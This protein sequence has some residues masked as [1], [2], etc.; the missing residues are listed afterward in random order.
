I[1]PMDTPGLSMSPIVDMTTAHSFNQVF[2]DDMRLPVSLR[3][4]EEG[5][6][7]RLAKVTLANERV[8]LSSAGSLWGEGPSAQALL[9]L[10]RESVEPGVGVDDPVVRDRLA[11]L[12][13]EAEVLRLNR[14]RSLSAT[15]QG[16]T[17]G[18]EASIQK[19]MADEHGQHVMALAKDL[20]GTNGMLAGSGPAGAIPARLRH[21][22]TEIR[23]PRGAASQ[24]PDVDP[25]WH[26]G[27]LFSPALTLGGGT[28]AVQRN[29]VAEQVLGLPR[30]PDV[31]RG[32]SWAE[33]RARKALAT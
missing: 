27:Y 5:D 13:C 14:L 20:A 19:I 1:C 11:R 32:M 28:F 21:S 15:L 33:T 18:A 31:E 3:V 29:I 24:Y 17:P 30:E 25:I 7:W 4:G 16:R 23:F 2:F 22:P 10:V 26:Y 9:D 6:G 8:S 12:H